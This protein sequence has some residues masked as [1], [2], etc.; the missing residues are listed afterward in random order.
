ME[1]IMIGCEFTISQLDLIETALNQMGWRDREHSKQIAQTLIEVQM[2]KT[3]KKRKKRL[4]PE[5]LRNTTT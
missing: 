1:K 5:P 4:M 2:Q 3:F